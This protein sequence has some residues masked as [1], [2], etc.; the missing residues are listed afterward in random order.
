MSKLFMQAPKNSGSTANIEGHQYHIPES[1]KIEVVSED[2]I[3]TLKRHGF[4][5]CE[6]KNREEL[7]QFI[8]ESESKDEL[9]KFIEERGGEADDSMGFK[10]LRRLATE[11]LGSE[12]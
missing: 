1:G 3:E 11:A 12:D 10:R 2:H 4:L 9:V 5:D 8:E 7:E 6:G